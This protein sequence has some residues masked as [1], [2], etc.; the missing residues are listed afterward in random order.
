MFEKLIRRPKLLILIDVIL[1]IISIFAYNFIYNV[2]VN[3]RIYSET[4]SRFAENN[5]DA[6]FR[7]EKII[8]YFSANAVDNSNGNL[9][10]IDISQYTDMEIYINNTS[11]IRE[12]TAENTV[13]ELFIDNIKIN[14]N[15]NIGT[16]L[17]NYKNP[18]NCG[19]YVN[20]NNYA[21]DG[22]LFNIIKS[23]EKLKTV[24]YENNIFYT[25][26][27][28]PISLGYVNKNIL[29]GCEVSSD[30]DGTIMFDG[31]ILKAINFD[32]DQ[33]KAKISMKIHIKNNYNEEYVCNF[34]I[35]ND[36]N[37]L[38]KEIYTGYYMKII[39]P[40]PDEY[41]FLKIS[42]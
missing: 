8:L 40:Q 41:T 6:T 12:L 23:N 7:I 9:Q 34:S 28:N 18:Q 24:D 35:D 27:S 21:N 36:V 30:V 25:D 31:S 29:T 13:N 2:E 32:L 14:S 16:K 42:N 38:A 26:C 1:L 15:S 20:L 39:T 11:K 5:K 37:T 22:I 19:K 10:D 4:S 3:K 33:L 17:I